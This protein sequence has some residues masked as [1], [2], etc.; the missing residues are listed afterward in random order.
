MADCII[1]SICAAPKYGAG[2]RRRSL[3]LPVSPA[4]F[5]C[6]GVLE[7]GSPGARGNVMSRTDESVYDPQNDEELRYCALPAQ[8]E[9]VIP[10]G[11]G[12]DHLSAILLGRTKWVN[13]TVLHYYFFDRDTDG[14]R[15]RFPDGTTR[16]VSWVGAKPQRD[17]VRRAFE[18]WKELG[19]GLEFRE[20]DDRSEAELRIGF[21]FD[22]DGSWSYAGRDVLLQGMN[23]RTMNFGWD[24]TSSPHGM[25]TALHEI[26]HTVGLPHEHQNP[27]AGIV[28][29][30][31]KV[32]QYF[33]GPPNNWDRGKTFH[34][35][36]RKLDPAEVE[37]SAWDPTSI[38][39]YAFR[40]GLIVEP[41]EYR[42]AGV[43]PP[44]TISEVDKQ[45]VLGW[46]PT[47]G[48]EAPPTLVPFQSVPLSLK[49]AE[50]AD[51]T[52]SPPATR[53]YDLGTFGASDT[54]LVLFEEVGGELRYVAGDDDSGE[55]RNSHLTAKLFQGR[56]YVL[57]VRL[58]YAWSSGQT[59]IMYW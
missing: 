21:L 46:Y 51:F 34:N 47:I 31:A 15:I 35:V 41:E 58:Y 57:R 37:G 59:A 38:M 20:V 52:L 11:L 30:E 13:G 16:F 40:A 27:F 42:V 56:R 5:E 28:W 45:Y 2:M 10:P 39:E 23:S 55:D 17:V 12:S 4:Y 8:P 19:I 44:G 25:S 7:N 32:Y 14:S 3:A 49:P 22:H 6:G 33:T 9:R 29:D 53:Q 36:L 48:D 24:L 54:V 1:R 26:G 43:H 50:Q 18:T